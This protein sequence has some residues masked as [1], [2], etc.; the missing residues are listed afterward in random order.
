MRETVAMKRITIIRDETVRY[1]IVKEVQELGATGYTEFLVGGKGDRGIRSRHG[2]PPN[3]KI[4]V[5]ATPEV[6]QKI[7]D[8][9][10]DHYFDDYAMIAFIDDVQVVRGAKFGGKVL[11]DD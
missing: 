9:I 3:A 4:E 5:V 6:A 7:L 11:S 10:A 2:E 8:H 1:R